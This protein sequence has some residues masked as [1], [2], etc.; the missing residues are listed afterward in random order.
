MKKI[1]HEI[2]DVRI[3]WLW[4]DP[5]LLLVMTPVPFR[6][7]GEALSLPGL[8]LWAVGKNGKRFEGIRVEVIEAQLP[9]EMLAEATLDQSPGPSCYQLAIGE[10]PEKKPLY[11]YPQKPMSDAECGASGAGKGMGLVVK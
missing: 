11:L 1:K 9:S 10:D 4:P 5:V 6:I 7:S 2:S 3:D 8:K